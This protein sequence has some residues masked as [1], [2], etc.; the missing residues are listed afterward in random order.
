LQAA[1]VDLNPPAPRI[2]TSNANEP[3]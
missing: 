3:K 1:F 2:P